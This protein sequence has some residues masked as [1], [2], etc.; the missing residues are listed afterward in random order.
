MVRLK[1]YYTGKSNQITRH[2]LARVIRA[3]S[4]D[5]ADEPAAAAV[6]HGH[7][8]MIGVGDVEQPSVVAETMGIAQS[9][10]SVSDTAQVSSDFIEDP[11]TMPTSITYEEVSTVN[12]DANTTKS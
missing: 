6:V 5:A 11:H 8:V 7:A 9:L 12:I 3:W 2:C 4:T 10:R 1:R